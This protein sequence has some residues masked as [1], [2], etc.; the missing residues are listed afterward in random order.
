M[1]VASRQLTMFQPYHGENKFHSDYVGFVQYQ[2]VQLDLCN[3]ISRKQHANKLGHII[4]MSSQPSLFFLV[5]R[6]YQGNN[7][8]QLYNLWFDFT[9]DRTHDLQ[10]SG[11]VRSPLHD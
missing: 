3:A 7:K 6:F 9:G 1:I 8:F 10:H 4:M 2:N 11:R 5:H